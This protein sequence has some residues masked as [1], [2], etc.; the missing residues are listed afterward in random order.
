LIW[1]K[2]ERDEEKK[3]SGRRR[4]KKKK[5]PPTVFLLGGL[6][7][8]KKERK[9]T[10]KFKGNRWKR[11]KK[12]GESLFTWKEEKGPLGPPGPGPPYPSAGPGEKKE[13]REIFTDVLGGRRKELG[14]CEKRQKSHESEKGE[15]KW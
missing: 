11:K 3:E 12:G 14:G 15:E 4:A 1:K 9:D 10:R 7:G 8:K 5:K 2:G 13:G 6:R